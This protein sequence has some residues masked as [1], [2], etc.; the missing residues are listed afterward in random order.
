M[1]MKATSVTMSLVVLLLAT[2]VSA[3]EDDSH[4]TCKGGFPKGG[5][6]LAVVVFTLYAAV[7]ATAIVDWMDQPANKEEEDEQSFLADDQEAYLSLNGQQKGDRKSSS[8]E[9]EKSEA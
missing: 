3:D 8:F 1:I 6:A 9:V 4:K 7:L 2:A 5:I